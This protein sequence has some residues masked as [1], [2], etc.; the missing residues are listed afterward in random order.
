MQNDTE[1]VRSFTD[2]CP[3]ADGRKI[4]GYINRRE[5]L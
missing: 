3:A 5:V 1:C 2:V 4:V